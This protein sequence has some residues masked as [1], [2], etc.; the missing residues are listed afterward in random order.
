MSE[1][2]PIKILVAEDD[3]VQRRTLAAALERWGY[4]P[5]VTSDGEQA[6]QVAQQEDAPPLAILDWIMPGLN[7]VELCRRLR[8]GPRSYTYVLLLTSKDQPQDVEDGLEQGADDYIKKPVNLQE[9]KAH[10][11]AGL[12]IVELQRRLGLAYEAARESAR[13]CREL[14]DNANDVILTLAADGSITSANR[15]AES[16]TGYSQAEL[17][18]IGLGR[19]LAPEDAERARAALA[20]TENECGRS[21]FDM[22]IMT[23]NGRSLMLDASARVVYEAGAARGMQ[24]IA[25]DVTE[26]RAMEAQLRDAYKMEAVGRLAAGLAHEFNNVLMIIRSNCELLQMR[27][28]HLVEEQKYMQRINQANERGARLIQQLL[29]FSGKQFSVPR[30]L[31][32]TELVEEQKA[33]LAGLLGENI[34]LVLCTASDLLPVRADP[35]Q[36]QQVVFEMA[37]YGRASMADGGEFKITTWNVPELPGGVKASLRGRCVALSFAD[38]GCGIAAGDRTRIFEPFFSAYPLGSRT[39]LG[40]ASVHG[41]VQQSGGHIEVKSELGKGSTFIIYLPAAEANA[42]ALEASAATRETATPELARKA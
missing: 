2:K 16:L 3:P 40:P 14:F 36:M 24:V 27:L 34:R 28:R 29:A 6:W 41:I 5:V 26:P 30:L 15:M 4:V 33:I 8:K 20:A 17:E 18:S 11:G 7:G 42:D 38:T 31:S 9:L 10:I 37:L 19:L 25:R 39:G 1:S 23:K 32:L 35:A 21:R 13:K 12:R 22:R